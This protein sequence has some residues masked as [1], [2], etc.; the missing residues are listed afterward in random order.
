MNLAREYFAGLYQEM[1]KAIVVFDEELS[2]VYRT[3]RAESMK[4]KTLPAEL[5]QA[6]RRCLKEC[7]GETVALMQ[8]GK[9]ETF[10]LVPQ[11]Y[12]GCTYLVLEGEL[13]F[14]YPELPALLRVLKNSREK[15]AGYL[16]GIYSVAQRMGL[17]TVD[18]K[19]LGED[20]RRIIRMTD[21]LDRILESDDR[22]LY[23]VPIDVGQFV[24]E[25]IRGLRELELVTPLFVSA[26][27]EGMIV[28][29]MP[30]D[31]EVALA[32]LVSNAMRFARERVVV[33][34]IRRDGKIRITV[35]DD[36]PGVEDPA[37]LFEWGYRT[38][39]PKGVVGLGFGLAVSRQ[40]LTEQGGTLLYERADGTTRFHIDL[41]EAEFPT[42][43]RL[44]AWKAEPFENSLS[45]MRVELS[46][47]MKEM[48]L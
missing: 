10:F 6:A 3:V 35:T 25:Y 17:N 36:G 12:D 16:N 5:E 2:P 26:C 27:E 1:P 33:E 7:R 30:E 22:L 45:K 9:E 39:D 14:S 31:L 8:D 24:T 21:H 47:Y 42:S 40:I 18:G 19:E 23:R 41:E 11:E 29:V 32:N 48:N 13:R 38:A 34:T 28:K 37:R 43:G 44:A 15:L 46:D 4:G 20:V